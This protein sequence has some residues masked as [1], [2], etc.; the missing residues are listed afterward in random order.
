MKEKRNLL[1]GIEKIKSFLED[2]PSSAGVYQMI[3]DKG[4]VLYVGK[5]KNLKKRVVSYTK[6]EALTYRIQSMVSQVAQVKTI[7]TVNEEKAIILE[8]DLI[9]ELSPKYNILMKD[10]KSFPYILITEHEFPKIKKHRIHKRK[11]EKGQLFGPFIST[12][13]LE[14]KINYIHKKFL[15]RSCTDVFFK[16]TDRP[17]LEYQIKRC[18][19]PCVGYITKRK[20]NNAVKKAIKLLEEED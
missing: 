16:T 20:Y 13:E 17:C 18:S 6:P 9:K 4:V 5:A 7:T 11:P 12:Q 19:A 15:L 3:D 8:A 1:S 10:D 2:M 14:D